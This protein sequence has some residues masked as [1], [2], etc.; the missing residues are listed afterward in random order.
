[1]PDIKQTSAQSGEPKK[2]NKYSLKTAIAL[3]KEMPIGL[4]RITKG[5]ILAAS[6]LIAVTILHPN[7]PKA[8]FL[9]G[10]LLN[11]SIIVAVI[12]QAYIYVGQWDTMERS[13]ERTDDII[14]K[15]QAQ[16][17]TMNEGL[18]IE[19]AKTDPRL[20]V[21]KVR[22]ENFEAGTSP[23]FIVTIANDGLIDATGVEL[24]IGIKMGTD[25]EF[26]WID[27]QTVMIPARGEESYPVDSGAQLEQ[28]HIEG[29]N[30]TVPIEV[31][32]RVKYWPG[33]P[34]EPK[35]F[36]YKYLPWRG[37]RPPD[38]PQFV[39]CDFNPHLNI[40]VHLGAGRLTL[41]GH[42]VTLIHG[43]A[44]PEEAKIEREEGEKDET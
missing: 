27:P 24:H 10:S 33:S 23:I 36:C 29:F 43:K 17:G 1:M 8:I 5:T 38:I 25:K 4:R 18:A 14:K 13:L 35:E 6:V 2:A 21:S 26:N 37:D 31:R 40:I 41:T 7:L 15:M 28:E 32:V 22:I 34:T 19:R 42:P 16:L 44:T 39:P 11:L 3:Y 30:K 9:T 20:R 12:I